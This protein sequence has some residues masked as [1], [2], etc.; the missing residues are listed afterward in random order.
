MT[1][2]KNLLNVLE[3]TKDINEVTVKEIN[4]AFRK[5][6]LKLH[7]DKAGDE[8]TY[9]FQE[10]RNAHQL[11]IHHIIDQKS[12]E[13]DDDTEK[14]FKDNFHNFNFPCENQG[15]FLRKPGKTNSKFFLEVQ[16]LLR[17]QMALNVTE[18]R[19]TSTLELLLQSI[20]TI[21]QNIRRVAKY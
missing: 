12:H 1:D 6:A 7:P 4:V 11:L 15:S 5:L 21:I 2:F 14:F 10:L 16:I 20:S 18:A 13:D 3:I 8:K 9:A 19:S 17:I